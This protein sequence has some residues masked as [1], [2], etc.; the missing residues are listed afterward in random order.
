MKNILNFSWVI[1]II[2]FG[3]SCNPKTATQMTNP[4]APGFNASD[5]DAKAVA[6]ADEVM[7]AMGGRK[8]WDETRNFSWNFFGARSLLWD[9]KTGDVRIEAKKEDLTILVN[10]YSMKGQV[11][12]GGGEHFSHFPGPTEE[13]LQRS[14][15]IQKTMNIAAYGDSSTDTKMHRSSM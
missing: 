11:K 6:V 7:K 13:D 9:K 12:K 1:T 10:I 14:R 2:F 5:S 3:F 8:A 4:A 15:A